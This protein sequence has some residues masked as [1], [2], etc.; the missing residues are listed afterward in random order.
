MRG[1]S[2]L[3]N[4]A[5]ATTA[6]NR[7]VRLSMCL[8]LMAFPVVACLLAEPN[9]E[10]DVRQ[11]VSGFAETWTITTWKP[12]GGYLR[13][14]PGLST[15]RGTGWKGREAIQMH[16]A[17]SHGTIPA[18]TRSQHQRIYPVDSMLD[19]ACFAS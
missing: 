5:E 4:F 18:D 7:L 1:V 14:T 3:F 10:G 16:Q 2:S 11:T 17:F 15:Y 9:D 13:R 8:A 12:L 19:F 6:M